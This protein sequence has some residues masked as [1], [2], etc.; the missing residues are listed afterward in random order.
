MADYAAVP[1]DEP[2]IDDFPSTAMGVNRFPPGLIWNALHEPGKTFTLPKT[3]G[4]YD[5]DEGEGWEAEV[6]LYV[7]YE[8]YVS[9]RAEDFPI[10]QR[11]PYMQLEIVVEDALGNHHTSGLLEIDVTY[12]EG[13]ISAANGIPFFDMVREE[14]ADWVESAWAEWVEA[15]AEAYDVDII[16]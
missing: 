4:F 9:P 13:E 8:A 3:Y 10:G 12:T 6:A 5:P 15:W 16:D 7:E 1:Y 11:V 2:A 14:F